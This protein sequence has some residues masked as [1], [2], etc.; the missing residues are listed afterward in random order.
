MREHFPLKTI[1]EITAEI[2]E[3]T[4]FT[5]LDATN[6]FWQVKLDEPS[7]NC[8]RLTRHLDAT[9]SYDYRSE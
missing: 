9:G 5:K 8:V 1:E 2:E 7:S 4:I 3:A 6:G